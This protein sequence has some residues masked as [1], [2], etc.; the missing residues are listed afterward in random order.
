MFLFKF[1]ITKKTNQNFILAYEID[2][3]LKNTKY[4]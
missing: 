1:K 3:L 4:C 2:K